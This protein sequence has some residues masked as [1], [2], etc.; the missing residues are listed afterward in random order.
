MHLPQ[1]STI[2]I[3]FTVI[4]VFD[5]PTY[6]PL[7]VVCEIT[8]SRVISVINLETNIPNF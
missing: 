2:S 6:L 8:N 3:T 4:E 5:S 7:S 1:H